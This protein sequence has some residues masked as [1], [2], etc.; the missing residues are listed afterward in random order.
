M[1]PYALYVTNNIIS[2]LPQEYVNNAS[3]IVPY[4]KIAH[5]AWF[6]KIIFT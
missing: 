5:Y 1:G 6:V 3:K 4:A 2:I